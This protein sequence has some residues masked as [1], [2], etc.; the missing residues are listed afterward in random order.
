M[1]S[2]SRI[3][4]A[5]GAI[6]L[7][8]VALSACG[9]DSIP[10]NAV[11]RVK[12]STISKADFDRWMVVAAQAVQAQAQNAKTTKVTVPDAPDY[13][14]CIAAK[15]KAAPPT[16]VGQPKPN[17]AKYKTAC[18]A[19]YENYK[20]Q[21][22]SFLISSEWIEAQAKE[23]GVTI[24]DKEVL[25][26][27]TTQKKQSF[28]KEA[29]YQKFLKSSGMT[30]KD[31]LLR[32]YEKN[33]SQ[34]AQAEQRDL[35]IIQTKT[36]AQANAAKAALEAGQSFASVAKE[37]SIDDATKNSGG[38]LAGVQKGQQEKALDEA[39]FAAQ[40][41]VITGPVKTSFGYYVFKVEKVTPMTQQT[42]AEATP[43]IKQLLKSQNE[44]K[45]L[46][47]FVKNF[48]EKWKAVTECRTG[49][50][51]ESCNNAPKPKK[52]KSTAPTATTTPR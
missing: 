37:F 18:K 11:A 30:E 3:V 7:A 12:D 39:A 22:M 25:K 9:G 34:F 45:A 44:Q 13:K 47:A 48:Q 43:S 36:E 6:F 1:T 17:A 24:T 46:A 29:D 51:V 23:L 40:E 41:G 33:K 28:P 49:Y 10:G 31:L 19:E 35:L 5:L 4:P 20:N 27:F 2:I 50:I 38:K 52:S 21:V 15:Q 26:Q 16:A 32:Y 42:L 8:S 14:V